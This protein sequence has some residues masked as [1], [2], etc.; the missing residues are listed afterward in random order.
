MSK[1]EK[2]SLV[3]R[4]KLLE[5]KNVSDLFKKLYNFS[6]M[7]A[8][9]QHFDNCYCNLTKH[10]CWLC[11]LSDFVRHCDIKNDLLR[12]RKQE[13]SLIDIAFRFLYYIQRI[14]KEKLHYDDE[15]LVLD[16]FRRKF[17][18]SKSFDEVVKVDIKDFRE[19]FFSFNVVANVN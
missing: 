17:D 6:K 1:I 15:K 13:D 18:T 16:F 9:D 5:Y 14:K 4:E 19:K 11:H 12:Y 10:Q 8:A 2:K 3:M 7:L